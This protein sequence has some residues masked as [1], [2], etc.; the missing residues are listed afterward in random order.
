MIITRTKSKSIEPDDPVKIEICGDKAKIG[1]MKCKNY[2]APIKKLP[3]NEYI[4]FK[5]GE[6][7]QFNRYQNRAYGTAINS[8]KKSMKKLKDYINTNVTD[9]NRA[10][11]LTL[12]YHEPMTNAKKLYTDFKSFNRACR[13]KYGEY[14]YIAVAEPG[15]GTGMGL[16]ER[17]GTWHLHIILIFDKPP[18]YMDFHVL[19]DKIWRKGGVYIN[20][21]R[22]KEDI[23]SYVTDYVS[24]LEI[25]DFRKIPKEIDSKNLKYV[26]VDENGRKTMKA[27]IKN[28][29]LPLY[30]RGFHFYR[31]SRGIRKPDVFKM[32]NE[33]AEDMVK[34]WDLTNEITY[35]LTDETTD[36]KN[37]IYNRFYS[38]SK[39]KYKIEYQ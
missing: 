3:G 27:I 18:P 29:R 39:P 32:T 20:K 36:F 34:D 21:V 19:K 12:N 25:D 11:W 23:G 8:L 5:T 9:L 24:D 30:P 1:Y 16:K 7:K 4:N 13:K 2:V 28:G 31:I 6:R 14:N 35:S 15:G 10:Y 38:K 33:E 22:D 37:I 17:V 26:E